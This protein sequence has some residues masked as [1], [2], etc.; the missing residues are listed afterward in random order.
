MRF[1]MVTQSHLTFLHSV[2]QRSCEPD[3]PTRKFIGILFKIGDWSYYAP[4]SSPKQRHLRIHSGSADIFK[5]FDKK[6]QSLG[7]V[8]LNNMIPVPKSEIIHFKI[9]NVA[10]QAY[11]NL[12]SDQIFTL[13]ENRTLI[14]N[15]A[16]S[17]RQDILNGKKKKLIARCCDFV[18]LEQACQTQYGP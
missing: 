2:D 18:R 1:C 13:F 11:K 16:T 4:L 12:L 10:D 8:N 6:N 3:K 5:L 9:K 15:K 17:L 14:K 7:V